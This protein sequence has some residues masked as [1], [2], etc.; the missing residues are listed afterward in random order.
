MYIFYYAR[1]VNAGIYCF[2]FVRVPG[3]SHSDVQFTGLAR[4]CKDILRHVIKGYINC[5]KDKD[6]QA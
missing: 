5:C 4:I 1:S 6:S 2:G 3:L